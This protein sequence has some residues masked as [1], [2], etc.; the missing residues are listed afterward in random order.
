MLQTEREITFVLGG[1]RSGKSR[2][3]QTFA[4]RYQRVLF[5]ATAREVDDEMRLKIARHR[6]D[7][8]V[9]WATVEEPL[10][11]AGALRDRGHG[12]EIVLIDCLTLWVSNLFAQGE[13]ERLERTQEFY[14]VLRERRS[15]VVIV[16]NEVGSGIVPAY[17]LGR[18]YRDDLGEVNQ[19]VAAISNHV[20]LLI[21]GIPLVLKGSLAP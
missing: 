5:V 20:A 19:R 16:S 13:S 2:F 21:A 9:H 3:A 15:R 14:E 11:L 18:A 1:V 6:E 12:Y 4:A 8:P 7:R 17:A 10:D